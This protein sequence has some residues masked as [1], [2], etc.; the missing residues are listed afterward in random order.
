MKAA[1]APRGM[2]VLGALAVALSAGALWA[3]IA[4]AGGGSVSPASPPSS[5]ASGM[6]VPAARPAT[7]QQSTAPDGDCPN[8]GGGS[9]RSHGGDPPG[10]GTSSS[11]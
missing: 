1:T 4:L 8:M 2:L 6:V 5:P 10:S 11:V 9:S 7:P 3:G